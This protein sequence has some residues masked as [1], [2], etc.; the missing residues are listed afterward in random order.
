[1]VS[2]CSTQGDTAIRSALV[3]RLEGIAQRPSLEVNGIPSQ[4]YS[5]L[6]PDAHR[7]IPESSSQSNGPIST[8][9]EIIT[10]TQKFSAINR[11]EDFLLRGE[12][13]QAYQYAL[14]EKLWPHAMIIA[15][16]IDKESWKAVVNQF[17]RDE[18]GDSRNIDNPPFTNSRE[19]LRVV[20]SL[21]SG[22]GAAAVQ[23]LTSAS[24]SHRSGL[25]RSATSLLAPNVSPT[26]AASSP[27]S[28][29]KW[30]ETVSMILSNPMT[31]DSSGA[32][33]AL[34]DLLFSNQW[35]EAA[36]VWYVVIQCRSKI[37]SLNLNLVIF[38]H[39]KHLP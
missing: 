36:H 22:Q 10:P 31:V 20:Y 7:V 29:S 33:T 3:P 24:V 30:T 35:T 28:L 13:H 34:G 17:L 26:S 19:N 16:S 11:I 9:N 1:M 2:Q 6:M 25:Q 5:S 15:S 39:R 12:R 21:F 38:Y 8:S 14:D 37:I 23:E 27:E 18:L 32:L 4:G